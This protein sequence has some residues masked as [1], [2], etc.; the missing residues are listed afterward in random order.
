MKIGFDNIQYGSQYV[1]MKNKQVL[2]ATLFFTHRHAVFHINK[3]LETLVSAS[4]KM[5]YLT[6]YFLA[7]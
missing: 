3:R 2:H 1:L 5:E 4:F 7:M 6:A